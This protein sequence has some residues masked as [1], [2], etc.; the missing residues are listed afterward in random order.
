MEHGSVSNLASSRASRAFDFLVSAYP[1]HGFVIDRTEARLLFTKVL[2][3]TAEMLGLTD[4]LKEAALTNV[5]ISS[6]GLPTITFLSSETAKKEP[7]KLK[8][9]VRIPK[10][11]PARSNSNALRRPAPPAAKS[12]GTVAPRTG[13]NG[14]LNGSTASRAG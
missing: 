5:R 8:E 14:K 4:V 12:K 7:A 2:E 9:P 3:P 1:D 11:K 10:P 6:D 13:P